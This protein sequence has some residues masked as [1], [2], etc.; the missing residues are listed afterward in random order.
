MRSNCHAGEAAGVICENS[1]D[2][3]S[4]DE[5]SEESDYATMLSR[6]AAAHPDSMYKRA[7]YMRNSLSVTVRQRLQLMKLLSRL[8]CTVV[9]DYPHQ[10]RLRGMSYNILNVRSWEVGGQP[11]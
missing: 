9:A 11:T 2:S 10:G 3:D 4:I 1:S 8:D 7:L 5:S 6:L